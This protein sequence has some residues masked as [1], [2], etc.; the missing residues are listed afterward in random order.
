MPKFQP[1]VSGNPRG[2]PRGAAGLAAY[3]KKKLGNDLH[4]VVD[5]MAAIALGQR[6]ASPRDRISAAQWLADRAFGKPDQSLAIAST[7]ETSMTLIDPSKLSDVDLLK[8]EQILEQLA[9]LEAK[10]LGDG[11]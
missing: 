9:A 6:G 2:R 4:D 7:V 5:E 3:I 11:S 10:A 1:G 8:R